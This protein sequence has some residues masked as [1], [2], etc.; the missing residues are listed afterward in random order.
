MPRPCALSHPCTSSGQGMRECL[1]SCPVRVRCRIP[2]RCPDQLNLMSMRGA[3]WIATLK[4]SPPLV[5]NNASSSQQLFVQY[6][7]KDRGVLCTVSNA[8][9]I[10]LILLHSVGFAAGPQIKTQVPHQLCR[11]LFSNLHIQSKHFQQSRMIKPYGKI[12]SF[13]RI[14]LPMSILKGLQRLHQWCD[15]PGTRLYPN[16]CLFGH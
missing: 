4:S 6:N 7:T 8:G 10:I 3:W 11:K 5:H 16:Q 12:H 9:P 13:S 14:S 1:P 15:N 2:V